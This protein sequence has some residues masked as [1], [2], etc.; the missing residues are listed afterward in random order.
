MGSWQVYL[1]ASG[2][3]ESIVAAACSRI[4]KEVLHL[5][6][7]SFYGGAWSSFNWASLQEWVQEVNGVGETS[8]SDENVPKDAKLHV[9][10]RQNFHHVMQNWYIP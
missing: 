6:S 4:G 10:P 2:V 1:F 3:A 8:K 7:N 9:S 5:D